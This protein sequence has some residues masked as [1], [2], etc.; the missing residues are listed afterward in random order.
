MRQARLPCGREGS[1]VMPLLE[2]NHAVE[3]V[4]SLGDDSEN[5]QRRQML[6]ALALLLAA[7]ILVLIK[8][9]DFW[10]PPD[11][12]AQSESEPVEEP[13]SD[14][15]APSETAS[16][17]TPPQRTSSCAAEV[18]ATRAA[19][20]RRTQSCARLGAGRDDPRRSASA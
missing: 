7:L 17:A 9:R 10:F 1:H 11:L 19:P 12:P 13:S 5:K 3:I 16:T 8:D 2:E 18:E 4:P 6:V 15:K 20:G 14:V